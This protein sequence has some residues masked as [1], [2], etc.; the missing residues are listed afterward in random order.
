MINDSH[1]FCQFY[2]WLC[3]INIWK[4]GG[5]EWGNLCLMRPFCFNSVYYNP[6]ATLK[7]TQIHPYQPNTEISSTRLEA[8][9]QFQPAIHMKWVW[10]IVYIDGMLRALRHIT[11]VT[12]VHFKFANQ[13]WPPQT[14]V[15]CIFSCSVH[16]KCHEAIHSENL[17]G[18]FQ[19]IILSLTYLSLNVFVVLLLCLCNVYL[20]WAQ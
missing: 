13:P 8:C 18:V 7:P 9:N 5:G 6:W 20:T 19:V 1:A 12:F 17:N 2:F 4:R 16:L 10:S 3:T 14:G 15:H 11:V